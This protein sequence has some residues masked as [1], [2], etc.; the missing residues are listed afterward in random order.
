MT[1]HAATLALGCCLL[2]MCGTQA[3]DIDLN[4]GDLASALFATALDA[5]SSAS[6][7]LEIST[8]AG[9][10]FKLALKNNA[11]LFELK[12]VRIYEIAPSGVPVAE[13]ISPFGVKELLSGRINADV[14]EYHVVIPAALR[15]I[16]HPPTHP[17][18]HAR[19]PPSPPTT[20][21]QLRST[22][23]SRPN[24]MPSRRQNHPGI[25]RC[26]RHPRRNHRRHL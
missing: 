24:L 16:S 13:A 5:A 7:A 1:H 3:I 19:T 11:S 20:C 21:C 6:S 9:T 14:G 15:A 22:P 12:L 25:L 10:T 4:V 2:L 18:T 26:R 23:W 17:R 8:D